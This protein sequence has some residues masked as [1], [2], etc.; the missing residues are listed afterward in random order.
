MMQLNVDTSVSYVKH[1]LPELVWIGLLNE[2][3][4]YVKSARI[5]EIIYQSSDEIIDDESHNNFALIST[6]TK[7]N[8]EQKDSLIESFKEAD[9]L[10]ELQNSF[11]PIILLYDESPISFIGPPTTTFSLDYLHSELKK[12]V[13]KIIDKYNTP[14]IVLLGSI[15][16]SSL[17]TKKIFFSKDIDIP[18]LNSVY[19]SPESDEAKRAAGFIRS[20]AQ[21]QFGMT[22]VSPD[23]AKHFWQRNLEISDCEFIENQESNEQ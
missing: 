16:L 21:A 5:Q 15:L 1:V 10:I 19:M 2:R 17:V 23:W 7:L 20:G 8:S 18:D 13:G 12:C 22:E 6:Y 3:N 14:G 4:G 9:I 11:A